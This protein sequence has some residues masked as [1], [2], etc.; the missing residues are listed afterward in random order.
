MAFGV[1]TGGGG[2]INQKL[3]SRQQAMAQIAG[4]IQPTN[5]ILN[6]PPSGIQDSILPGMAGGL[7]PN[8]PPPIYPGVNPSIVGNSGGTKP[9]IY[10]RRP[11]NPR[12]LAMGSVVTPYT[13]VNKGIWG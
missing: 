11:K 9:D 10:N 12:Q 6:L 1:P 8:T 4:G 2:F 13:G 7:I 5:P 3:N